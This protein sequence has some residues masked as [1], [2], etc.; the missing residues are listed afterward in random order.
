MPL[1]NPLRTI[2]SNCRYCSNKAGVLARD[3]PECRR[4]FDAGWDR[5]V[6]L[7]ADAAKTHQFDEKSLR[8]SLAEMARNSYRSRNAIWK[9]QRMT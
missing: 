1:S 9:I 4:T 2:A 3:H 5:M 6:R 8:L 7:A